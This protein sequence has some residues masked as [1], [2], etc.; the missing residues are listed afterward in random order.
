MNLTT[1]GLWENNNNKQTSQ[2]NKHTLR[3]TEVAPPISEA[4]KSGIRKND[5]LMTVIKE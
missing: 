5:H 3:D 4:F 2:A 1:E